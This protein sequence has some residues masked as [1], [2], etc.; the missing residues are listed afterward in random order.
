MAGRG[1]AA[2]QARRESLRSAVRRM[3]AP[4]QG[5]SHAWTPSPPVSLEP[6]HLA[7]PFAGGAPVQW[8][9]VQLSLEAGD[10]GNVTV[11]LATPPSPSSPSASPQYKPSSRPAILLFHSTGKCKEFIA[12]HLERYAK[13]GFIAAAFDA[14]YHGE[15]ALPGAGL[16]S[17]ALELPRLGPGLLEPILNTEPQRLQVYHRAL[18][19]AWKS[20]SERPF[21]YDTVSDGLQVLD[22][23]A[24]RPD[25]DAARIGVAGV[26]LGGM[27]TWLLAAA[28]ERVAAA[29]PAIGVQSF[30]FAIENGI[31]G[32]RVDTIRPVFEV[33]SQDL[34]RTK[35]DT[36]TVEAVWKRLVPGLADSATQAGDEPE[37]AFDAPLSLKCIAP[38]PLLVLN[39]SEDPRCPI[40][41]VHAAIA[42]AAQE[43]A[44]LGAPHAIRLFVEQGI[45]HEMTPAMWR[46][47]DAF[48]EATLL[49]VRGDSGVASKGGGN[50][51][52]TSKL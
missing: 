10:L 14:R 34:G 29:A 49:R 3:P 17:A 28:D 23:L 24:G 16:P 8:E 38:R 40:E 45:G 47:I 43:Y 9:R 31:W 30:R 46:Q 32:P 36:A 19:Q 35:V 52:L 12:E 15:R 5:S 26:S 2:V 20:G 21:L 48:F 7:A 37:W 39:G 27:H 11:L 18:V 4:Q 1:S 33:A 42:A 51:A 6:A 25:V 22:Y 41:G 50:G 44:A 13:Q